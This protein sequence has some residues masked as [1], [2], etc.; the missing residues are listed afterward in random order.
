MTPTVQ[1]LRRRGG[2]VAAIL[3]VLVLAMD[4][5]SAAEATAADFA[6]LKARVQEIQDRQEIG[7]LIVEYGHLLDTHELVGYSQLFAR[8]GEWI[9]GFGRAKG[10]NAILAMMNKYIGTAP[11][12]HAT[13]RAFT[14]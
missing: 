4:A 10:P 2:A 1:G 14:C 7:Q 6:A 3:A 8:E 11:L 5:A 12:T 13:S 9:G